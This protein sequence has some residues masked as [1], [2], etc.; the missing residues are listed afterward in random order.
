MANHKSALK[1]M[2]SDARKRLYNRSRKRACTVLIKR[3][4]KTKEV[5][6]EMLTQLN[7]INSELDKLALKGIL[8][9]NKRNNF[10]SKLARHVHV[11]HP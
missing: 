11:L 5:S 2:R 4:L 8:H 1:R 10:K 3:L 7:K 6:K 9:K